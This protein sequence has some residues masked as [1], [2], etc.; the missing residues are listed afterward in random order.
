MDENTIEVEETEKRIEELTKDFLVETDWKA[1][2]IESLL[3]ELASTEKSFRE[4]LMK[5]RMIYKTL[6][7]ERDRRMN[8]EKRK[9]YEEHARIVHHNYLVVLEEVRNKKKAEQNS[10]LQNSNK[11]TKRIRKGEIKNEN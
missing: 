4:L 1:G 2:D 3:K 9:Y 6:F 10:V 7:A 8:F 5:E 11:K